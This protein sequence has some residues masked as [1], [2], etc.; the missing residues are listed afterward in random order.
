MV[1]TP[2]EARVAA[3]VTGVVLFLWPVAPWL[4]MATGHPPH[5][6]VPEGTYKSNVISF[7]PSAVGTPDFVFVGGITRSLLR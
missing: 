7:D 1:A 4:A 3:I 6:L 2:F 5:G